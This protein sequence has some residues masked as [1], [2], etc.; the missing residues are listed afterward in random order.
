MFEDTVTRFDRIN[1]RA[2]GQTDRQTPHDG[3]GRAC[4]ASRGKN[5]S[6][7]TVW[8]VDTDTRTDMLKTI[9]AYA[10]AAGNYNERTENAAI[11]RIIILQL[12]IKLF[13][14]RLQACNRLGA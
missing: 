11:Y 2:R 12:T 1:E 8:F 10:I 3:I 14:G 7:T 5:V 9:R 13:G 6:R 4:I